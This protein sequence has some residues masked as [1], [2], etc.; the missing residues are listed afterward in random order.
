M[1]LFNFLNSTTNTTSTTKNYPRS[2]LLIITRTT[3]ILHFLNLY[4]LN[5]S[6]SY[7]YSYLTI[8]TFFLL[9]TFIHPFTIPTPE[10]VPEP[11]PNPKNPKNNPNSNQK[12]SSPSSSQII[13]I[14][15]KLPSSI[16]TIKVGK[17]NPSNTYFFLC[18]IQDRFRPLLYNSQT[19]ISTAKY[20]TSIANT[21]SIPIIA[22]QQ[23]TKVFGPTVTDCFVNG[24][25]GM[26]EMIKKPKN[27][28][29]IF[30]KKKFSMMTD[31]VLHYY[32]D[33][34]NHSNSNSSNRDNIVLF[35]IEAHVCVQQTCLDLIEMGKNVHIVT[36]CVSSQ[37]VYDREIALRRMENA[38][39][40][41]TTAQSLA[42]MLMESKLDYKY[43][44]M[45]CC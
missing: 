6:Y 26:N 15:S 31:E 14:T 7:S 10:P 24:I 18:D 12:M 19:I 17:L 38:G 5:Y 27:Q 1:R 37:Q 45:Y 36:D 9:P 34:T 32:N 20:L 35:G 40:F 22:T 3:T 29:K 21:L 4:F 39:A 28:L 30:E 8:T 2:L 44:Y 23:Y 43:F 42:F 13:N 41:L 16:R 25:D 11:V 33:N